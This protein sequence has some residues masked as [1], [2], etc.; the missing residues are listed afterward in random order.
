MD[1][2]LETSPSGECTG[3]KRFLGLMSGLGL[4][5]VLSGLEHHS[6]LGSQVAPGW[7]KRTR[8]Q[9]RRV[10][11]RPGS[12]FIQSCQVAT[13]STH[14]VS[15]SQQLRRKGQ[16]LTWNVGQLRVLPSDQGL[17]SFCCLVSIS[18]I[19]RCYSR[20]GSWLVVIGSLSV[21]LCNLFSPSCK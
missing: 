3:P 10:H 8:T 5:P 2:G 4:C 20:T 13:C 21:L 9:G 18:L 1:S 7:R 19:V 12:G 11:Q 16:C 6:P 17:C 15:L 14:L